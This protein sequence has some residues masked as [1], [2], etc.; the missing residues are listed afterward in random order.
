MPTI[1]GIQRLF[2][3]AYPPPDVAERLVLLLSSL[4]L[5]LHASTP[6]DQIHLT[7]QFIGDTPLQRLA[8]VTESVERSV[9]GLPGFTLSPLVLRTLPLKG[10]PR[11]IAVQTDAPPTL[12]EIHRRL[13]HRLA[14]RPRDA[15][16][17][18]FLPHLTLARFNAG[19]PASPL[20]V[21]ADAPPFAVTDI[22]LV[23]SRLRTGGA[24]HDTL[25]VFPLT[26]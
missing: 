13:V 17:E 24:I 25:A 23:R 10:P 5:P 7:L 26:G 21:P 19:L 1:P 12:L 15:S 22:R 3:A 11:L 14:R 9:S 18:P 16:A 2:V 8:E 6:H 20:T 4:S